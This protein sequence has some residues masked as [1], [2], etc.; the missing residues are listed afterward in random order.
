MTP[1]KTLSKNHSSERS[2]PFHDRT[3]QV[4]ILICKLSLLSLLQ[5]TVN[6]VSSY[7]QRDVSDI[8]Q[9]TLKSIKVADKGVCVQAS[10]LG[11][12]EA[13]LEFLKTS[14]IPVCIVIYI[15]ERDSI[16]S[17]PQLAER[18]TIANQML[19]VQ[20]QPRSSK[21]LSLP[22][23]NSEN[24][25]NIISSPICFSRAICKNRHL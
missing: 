2:L 19:R 23:V 17:N 8:V 21:I 6:R 1:N 9:Q 20:F 3:T 14:K 15:H 24:T 18:W 7:L 16:A 4:N 25:S 10:T 11:S 12:L 5:T 13:L 22:N